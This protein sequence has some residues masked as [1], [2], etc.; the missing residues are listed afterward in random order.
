MRLKLTKILIFLCVFSFVLLPSGSILGVNIKAILLSV[1]FVSSLKLPNGKNK[2]LI[3]NSAALAFFIIAYS[4]LAVTND[5][6]LSS[7]TSA[8]KAWLSA[9]IPLFVLIFYVKSRPDLAHNTVNYILVSSVVYSIAK[10]TLFLGAVAGIIDAGLIFKKMF[11]YFGYSPITYDYGSFFRINTPTDFVLVPALLVMFNESLTRKLEI[12]SNAK[13]IIITSLLVALIISLSRYIY[14]YA[15]VSIILY[16]LASTRISSRWRALKILA[17]AAPLIL[18]VVYSSGDIAGFISERYFGEYA[19][20]SD[21]VREMLLPLL[22]ESFISSFFFGNGLGAYVKEVIIF[23]D[24]PWNYVLLWLSFLNQFGVAGV[25]LLVFFFIIPI[26]PFI[27]KI[28]TGVKKNEVAVAASYLIF[29]YSGVFNTFLLTS[30]MSI[31]YFLY[32]YLSLHV[33][34]P[35]EATQVNKND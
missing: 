7:V 15:I 30:S 18:V 2:Y 16:F 8:A 26:S 29:L 3:I 9:F 5:V 31:L 27:K 11:L 13:I 32:Y 4:L 19:Q 33:N 6:R 24:A 14:F 23:E 17:I 20:K 34:Q 1:L 35:I 25:I 12:K 28:K 10:I 22:L 21:S